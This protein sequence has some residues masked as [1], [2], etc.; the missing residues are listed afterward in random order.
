MKGTVKRFCLLIVRSNEYAKQG[1]FI[2]QYYSVMYNIFVADDIQY[3]EDGW[4][5]VW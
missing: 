1:F 5:H 2:S 3:L 4:M